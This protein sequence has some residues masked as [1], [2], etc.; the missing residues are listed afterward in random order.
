MSEINTEDLA[1]EELVARLN[2]LIEE[3]EQYPD[4]E[5]R[6][7]ALDLVQIILKLYGE[8]LRR[9]I[10]TFEAEPQRDQILGRMAS[11]EVIRS[12]LLIHGLMPESLYDR[13]AAKLKVLRPFL[14]SQGC[15]V[16]L[17]GVDDN[18]ARV[19]LIRSGKGA[20]PLTVLKTDIEKAL[21]EVAPDLAGIEVEG[22]SEKIEATAKATA[23]LGRMI[24][25]PEK[26]SKPTLVQIKRKESMRGEPNTWV[27]VIRSQS[28]GSGNFKIL[29]FQDINVL[30]SNLDGEFYAYQN[31]CAEGGRPLDDALF[32]NPI[33]SCLCHGYG[34]DLRRGGCIARPDLHLKSVPLKVEDYKVKIGL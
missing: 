32:E 9:M 27:S 2:S 24:Q 13:V 21:I 23:A 12:I 1:G 34:Y 18:R 28:I 31:A 26:N 8:S 30:I 22:L 20:P 17:L 33:L 6:E 19:R 16:E 29:N 5:V 11:D 7:T 10:A 3:L 15:D 14:I 25:K 4:N